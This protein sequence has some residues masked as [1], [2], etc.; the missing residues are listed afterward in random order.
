MKLVFE[1]HPHRDN[2]TGRAY[3]PP[4]YRAEGKKCTYRI[5][6][7]GKIWELYIFNAYTGLTSYHGSFGEAMIYA[8][9]HENWYKWEWLFSLLG[10]KMHKYL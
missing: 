9:K 2:T 1:K 5:E 6:E 10:N 3:R 4:D 7:E 8:Q